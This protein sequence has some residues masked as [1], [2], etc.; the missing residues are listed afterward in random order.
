MRLPSLLFGEFIARGLVVLKRQGC[1]QVDQ[2]AQ[3]TCGGESTGVRTGKE[4]RVQGFAPACRT[5]SGGETAYL[6]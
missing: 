5:I 1:A 3:K 2:S 4:T 6:F